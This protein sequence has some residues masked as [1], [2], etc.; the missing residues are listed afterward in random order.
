M[1][2]VVVVGVSLW[3]LHGD[4][5]YLCKSWPESWHSFGAVILQGSEGRDVEDVVPLGRAL[6]KA[7]C[8]HRP[9][10]PWLHTL[11]RALRDSVQSQLSGSTRCVRQHALAACRVEEQELL[12]GGSGAQ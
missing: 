3:E 12:H 4:A 7:V 2:V 5:L 8:T 1:V 9:F 11:Q 6:C 10:S